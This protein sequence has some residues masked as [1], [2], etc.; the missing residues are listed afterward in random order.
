ME[1]LPWLSHLSA[2]IVS[3]GTTWI[4]LGT[5][6]RRGLSGLVSSKFGYRFSAV[7]LT[8]LAGLIGIH[9]IGLA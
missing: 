9:S 1:M 4:F 5:L 2:L 6:L 8:L 7:V 3:V